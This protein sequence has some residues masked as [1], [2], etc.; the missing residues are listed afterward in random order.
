[1]CVS[2]SI[3]CGNE[4]EGGADTAGTEDIGENETKEKSGNA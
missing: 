1:M 2:E 4:L 3:K